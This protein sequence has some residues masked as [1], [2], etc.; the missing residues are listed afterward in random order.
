LSGA[1]S[2]SFEGNHRNASCTE[3]GTAGIC[4]S[5]LSRTADPIGW[6]VRITCGNGYCERRAA[7]LLTLHGH[8]TSVHSHQFLHERKSDA[9][10]FMRARTG[11]L[12]P[13]K[14][15]KDL[16]QLGF[17]NADAGVGHAQLGVT[18][19]AI[20][21]D[22]D[23]AFKRELEGFGK[24]VEDDLLPHLAVD[25]DRLVEWRA[26][27]DQLQLGLFDRGS[28]HTGKLGRECGK[29]GELVVRVHAAGFDA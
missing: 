26:I 24:Q 14:A 23:R 17:R 29:V 16:R 27:D 9:R 10:A 5:E 28:K 2:A 1:P 11:V 4:R 21:G 20:E 22:G 7:A 13:M 3:S 19:P 15:M 8:F 12:D 25:V 6:Q 18:L